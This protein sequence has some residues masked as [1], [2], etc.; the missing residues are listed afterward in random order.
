VPFERAGHGSSRDVQIGARS[1]LTPRHGVLRTHAE[2]ARTTG[3]RGS[4][5]TSRTVVAV[6]S[7]DFTHA[8]LACNYRLPPFPRHPS[9]RS[10]WIQRHRPHL[11][12]SRRRRC[13]HYERPTG[14]KRR[15]H[16]HR[17]HTACEARIA[18]RWNA[19]RVETLMSQVCRRSPLTMI[20][21]TYSKGKVKG[22][23]H[24]LRF[25]RTLKALGGRSCRRPGYGKPGLDSRAP[26]IRLALP[27]D[28]PVAAVAQNLR[29]PSGSALAQCFWAR[30]RG[31]LRLLAYRRLPRASLGT[32]AARG[33][34]PLRGQ[35]AARST[36]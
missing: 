8:A 14:S 11:R 7:S 25:S 26:F 34:M 27:V 24:F 30:P 29:I 13:D 3:T 36:Q 18:R 35:W 32:N 19:N 6:Q 9:R 16:R 1:A 20:P 12:L 31:H 23:G 17:R 15:L 10:S 2:P 21:C 28:A 33:S 5:A 22:R 4:R